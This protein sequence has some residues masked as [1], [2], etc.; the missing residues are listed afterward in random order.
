MARANDKNT[1]K[2]AKKRFIATKET[3][4]QGKMS[5]KGKEAIDKVF[6]KK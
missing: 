2:N 4:G 1:D 5:K 3:T 6:G